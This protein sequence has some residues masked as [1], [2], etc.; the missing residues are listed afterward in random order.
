[1]IAFIYKP[2]YNDPYKFTTNGSFWYMFEYFLKT[3]ELNKQTKFIFISNK[4]FDLNILK[5]CLE[6]KYIIDIPLNNIKILNYYELINHTKFIS[7]VA[8]DIETYSD[9]FTEKILKNKYTCLLYTSNYK[10]L[11]KDRY[12]KENIFHFAED[13]TYIKKYI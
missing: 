9:E 12:F 8:L 6:F 10:E 3:Y 2:V 5:N 4:K 13:N 11:I 7:I 1:M